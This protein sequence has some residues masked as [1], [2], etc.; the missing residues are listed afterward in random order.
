MSLACSA[1]SAAICGWLGLLGLAVAAP[2]AVAAFTIAIAGAIK[3]EQ[4]SA[5]WAIGASLV[6]P[7]V[8]LLA[9]FLFC[10][11][12]LGVGAAGTA[13]NL[14]PRPVGT[15]MAPS[16][17][18][19]L[20]PSWQPTM[21]PAPAV[22]VNSGVTQQPSL[23]ITNW[24]WQLQNEF[25]G[26]RTYEYFGEV[27]NDGPGVA[28]FAEVQASFYDAA[29]QITQE[30]TT[31]IRPSPLQPGYTGTFHGYASCTVAPAE[32]RIRTMLD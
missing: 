15:D 8:G 9:N 25:M 13:A 31:Y 30:H 19:S 16:V 11:A 4:M 21:D 12:L 10:G 1:V 32:C 28:S 23:R 6:F 3:W 22:P 14:A 20:S 27:V 24:R 7:S 18:P 5:V 26:E 29:G 17:G 2:F